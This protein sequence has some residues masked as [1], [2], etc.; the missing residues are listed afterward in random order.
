VRKLLHIRRLAVAPATLGLVLGCA[1]SAS[2][3]PTH[4]QQTTPTTPTTTLTLVSQVAIP[5]GTKS[6]Y[7]MDFYSTR[8]PSPDSITGEIGYTVSAYWS[9]TNNL[10]VSVQVVVVNGIALSASC[11]LG[12]I[13]WWDDAGAYKN[14]LEPA[15]VTEP[16]KIYP[17]DNGVRQL[18][19][20][21]HKEVYHGEGFLSACA[22]S[23]C[24]YDSANSGN[25]AGD[26]VP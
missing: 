23:E 19:A 3:A 6:T 5:N 7:D 15:G 22:P 4:P 26:A 2:A 20:Y 21:N 12:L 24:G 17:F 16:C 25:L 11:S 9:G 1:V 14:I 18:Y 10:A 13:G 8:T